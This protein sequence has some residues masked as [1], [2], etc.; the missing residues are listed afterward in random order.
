MSATSREDEEGAPGPVP[1]DS[2]PAAEYLWSATGQPDR[3]V[4]ALERLLSPLAHDGRPLAARPDQAGGPG[5]GWG[6]GWARAWPWAAAAAL[7]LAA[8]LFGAA[9]LRTTPEAGPLP[10]TEVPQALL[11]AAPPLPLVVADSGQALQPGQW[12]EATAE[13]RE[14]ELDRRLARLTL[15]PGSRLRLQRADAAATRLFLERGELDVFVSAEAR[16][17]FF[18][19]ET[20]ATTCVDL[21]CAYTLSVDPEGA[22]LVVVRSGRVVFESHGREVYVPTGATCRAGRQAGPGTPC[23]QDDAPPLQAAV[24]AFDAASPPD[25]LEQARRLL[26]LLDE[27]RHSLTAWHLLQD[28]DAA[29]VSAARAALTRLLNEAAPPPTGDAAEREA[30]RTLCVDHWPG[31][32]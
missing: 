1:E 4:A 24:A 19:V 2:D 20:P 27:P 7:L 11:P 5:R 3:E 31:A 6:R 25:R 8:G 23:F 29:I 30:W 12:F 26:A 16:P 21:G 15:T 13:A 14:L 32:W 18:Q 9:V 28:A 17:R 22:A 10:P